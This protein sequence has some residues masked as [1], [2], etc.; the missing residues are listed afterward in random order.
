MMMPSPDCFSCDAKREGSVLRES[1]VPNDP[2]APIIIMIDTFN[3]VW[4]PKVIVRECGAITTVANHRKGRGSHQNRGRPLHPIKIGWCNVSMSMRTHA[5]KKDGEES[6]LGYKELICWEFE[7]LGC[8]MRSGGCPGSF[9][10]SNCSIVFIINFFRDCGQINFF[11]NCGLN[12]IYCFSDS[13]NK[14]NIIIQTFIKRD[15][16]QAINS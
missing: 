1:V 10:F 2:L 8:S 5:D 14:N 7:A 12:A 9:H 3:Q 13:T 11:R 16:M 6:M 15:N 4:D